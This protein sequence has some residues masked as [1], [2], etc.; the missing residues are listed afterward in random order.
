MSLL[1]R[2][3]F[4][5]GSTSVRAHLSLPVSRLVVYQ[6]MRWHTGPLYKNTNKSSETASPI[7]QNGRQSQQTPEPSKYEELGGSAGNPHVC[8]EVE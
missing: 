5:T 2:P 3:L 8:L 4:R 1:P 7:F 6:Q